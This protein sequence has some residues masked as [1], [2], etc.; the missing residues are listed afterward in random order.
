MVIAMYMFSLLNN[1]IPTCTSR[2]RRSLPV[3]AVSYLVVF[4]P[5]LVLGVW[6]VSSSLVLN[7]MQL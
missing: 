1:I 3:K 6:V 7:V 2:G 4:A 5:P